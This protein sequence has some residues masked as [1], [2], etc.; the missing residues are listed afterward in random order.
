MA[1]AVVEAAPPEVEEKTPP[2]EPEA[3]KALA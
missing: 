1:L 3:V 2:S